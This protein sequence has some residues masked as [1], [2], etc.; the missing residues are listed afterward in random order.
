MAEHTNQNRC[1]SPI[2]SDG[3]GRS[4]YLNSD[5]RPSKSLPA[6]IRRILHRLTLI[7]IPVPS[8]LKLDGIEEIV[9]TGVGRMFFEYPPLF[10]M[11]FKLGI[12]V[13]DWL[14][15]FFG[16]GFSRFTR[17][18]ETHAEHYVDC[19]AKSRLYALREF[20]IGMK[21]LLA[22]VYFSDRRV[23]DYLGYDPD[24]HVAERMALREAILKRDG[25]V[26]Q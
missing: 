2:V 15:F 22:L 16:F 17:L 10:R 20:F 19:W 13:F 3:A 23:W 9:T 11:L 4:L 7:V 25:E 1:N 5:D 12:R 26:S 21:A 6:D 24:T 18:S 8:D 14:P